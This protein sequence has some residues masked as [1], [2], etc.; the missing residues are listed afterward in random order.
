MLSLQFAVLAHR[1]SWYEVS[2]SSSS[3]QP[4]TDNLALTGL[5][6]PCVTFAMVLLARWHTE[7]FP[8]TKVLL[9]SIDTLHVETKRS[10]P[11]F[12]NKDDLNSATNLGIR[13]G[14]ILEGL[15][16]DIKLRC[17]QN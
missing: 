14:V 8:V 10:K 11:V 16:H 7:A 3:V 17:V 12:L 4:C 9:A 2:F 1:H 13:F 15:I 6:L 5:F